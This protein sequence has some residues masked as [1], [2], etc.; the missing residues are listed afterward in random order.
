MTLRLQA[1]DSR[2]NLTGL[3]EMNSTWFGPKVGFD[4]FGKP[5]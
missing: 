5:S 2:L 4:C 3:G 1:G